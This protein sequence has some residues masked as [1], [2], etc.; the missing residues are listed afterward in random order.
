[1]VLVF[2]RELPCLGLVHQHVVHSLR[3]VFDY[4]YEAFFALREKLQDFRLFGSELLL[5]EMYEP[6]RESDRLEE[7]QLIVPSS[8]EQFM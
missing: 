7:V 2:P 1:M 8:E 6:L 4:G 5:C 3:V